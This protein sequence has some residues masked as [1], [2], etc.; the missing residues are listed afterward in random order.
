MESD[1][2]PDAW[3]ADI[4]EEYPYKMHEWQYGD[5]IYVSIWS[6]YDEN[7]KGSKRAIMIVDG[8]G[9]MWTQKE[10]AALGVYPDGNGNANYPWKNSKYT[11]YAQTT[12]EAYI[13]EGVTHIEH[14]GMAR[15]EYVSFP[16]TLKSVGDSCF[17]NSKLTEIILPEGVE[18]L[19]RSAFARCNNVTRIELPSTLKYIDSG[20]FR[21]AATHV[22]RNKN[23][24]QEVVIPAGVEYIGYGAFNY[25][26]DLTLI[27]PETL[28]TGNFQEE[29]NVLGD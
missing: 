23:L 15:L 20:A 26:Y 29:W 14:L 4:V 16:S 13:A 6:M 8:T 18:R 5:N 1:V 24:V 17:D 7:Y 28:N 27:V 22:S 9:E 11:K 12:Y 21:L 3:Y 10:A 2:D 19:E 25:R